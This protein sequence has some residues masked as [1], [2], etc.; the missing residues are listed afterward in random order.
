MRG[1]K[2]Y[3]DHNQNDYSDT[4]AAPYSV[5][6]YKLPLVSTPI[7]WTEVIRK[8]EAHNFTI[9]TILPRLIK[10]GDLFKDVLDDFFNYK[11]CPTS[12]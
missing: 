5:R 7:E 1:D 4:V 11:N 10:K 2:L 9:H 6:P 12:N 3:V 8:L